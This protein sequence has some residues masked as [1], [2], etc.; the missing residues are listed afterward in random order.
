MSTRE[1]DLYPDVVN[2]L[3]QYLK[4]R[5]ANSVISTFDT[6]R[7]SLVRLIQEKEL[8]LNL[9]PDWTSWDIFVDVVGFVISPTETQLALVECKNE[10]ITLNH[11]SQIIGYSRVVRPRYAFLTAPQG[12]SG[13]L[14]QLLNTF[15]RRDIL[16]YGTPPGKRAYSIQV[17]RWDV[18]GKQIDPLT[19]IDAS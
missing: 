16:I 2:W 5:H 7:K 14:S 15:N 17:G 9:P 13:A 6:S 3:A 19:L 4:D 10:A 12:V 8:M 1:A 18:N 11:L